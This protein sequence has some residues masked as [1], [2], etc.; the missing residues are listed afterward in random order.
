MSE[1]CNLRLPSVLTYPLP[2]SRIFP[3][4]QATIEIEGMSCEHCVNAVRQALAT[5]PTVEVESIQIGRADVRFDEATLGAERLTAAVTD[6]GYT[7][8]LGNVRR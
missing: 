4:T 6:A 7:A 3:M 5:L 1:T 8:R 2:L